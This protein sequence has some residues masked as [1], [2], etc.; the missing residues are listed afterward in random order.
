[1]ALIERIPVS[2]AKIY[3]TV[4]RTHSLDLKARK[5]LKQQL[6]CL[7]PPA[8]FTSPERVG[9]HFL[10]LLA[11]EIV[12]RLRGTASA[13]ELIAALRLA[14]LT[15]GPGGQLPP[16]LRLGHVYE[17]M[18]A[19]QE[20]LLALVKKNAELKLELQQVKTRT[21]VLV[22]LDDSLSLDPQSNRILIIGLIQQL[23]NIS[24]GLAYTARASDHFWLTRHK[25]NPEEKS[26][27][28]GEWRLPRKGSEKAFMN[29]V[30]FD[31]PKPDLPPAERAR[32]MGQI[33][34]GNCELFM[35]ENWGYFYIPKREDCPFVDPKQITIDVGGDVAQGR[36]A[37]GES[38]K[39]EDFYFFLKNARENIIE[40]S[41][42]HNWRT[43]R[44]LFRNMAKDLATLRGFAQSCSKAM[45]LVAAHNE[46]E[47]LSVTD[48]LTG[49]HNRRYFDKKIRREVVRARASR[50]P[51]QLGLL[52]IDI[53]HFKEIND[54]RGHQAG[55]QVLREAAAIFKEQ[56]RDWLDSVSRAGSGSDEFMVVMPGTNEN[57]VAVVA[58][59]IRAAVEAHHFNF[60]DGRIIP[61]TVSVGGSVYA[62]PPPPPL[63]RRKKNPTPVPEELQLAIEGLT[64]RAD[65]AL[66]RA[67]NEL[68]RN[69]AAV[70]LPGGSWLDLD[71]VV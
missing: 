36:A 7:T 64:E 63:D 56:V 68:G 3:E 30:L 18:I 1:M 21:D 45:E 48:P 12:K 47:L 66:Y 59:R 19:E 60:A 15:A 6:F 71:K 11:N 37:F 54:G 50:Q 38:A 5:D 42:L 67:K 31:L 40:V 41:L 4:A 29:E 44:P 24:G 32:I 16:S 13:D 8:I 28:E 23:L 46:L 65:Q 51:T 34:R 9:V 69:N 25:T 62:P 14:N 39:G 53:D 49:L 52:I 35:D 17:A 20:R 2:R 33:E 43:K 57:G 70:R 27:F 58:K 22:K 10:P 26:E 61:V 55:D